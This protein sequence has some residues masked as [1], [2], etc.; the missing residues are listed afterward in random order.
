V[1]ILCLLVVL[2]I[3]AGCSGGGY[4]DEALKKQASRSLQRIS[5]A[6]EQYRLEFK[7]YPGNG[8]DLGEVLA[9]YFVVTDTAGNVL[10]EWSDMV[11]N[12]FWGDV[13]YETPDSMH[14]YFI[15]VRALDTRHTPLT[16][17]SNL[18][19]EEEETKKKKKRR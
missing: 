1:R 14:S 12:S 13:G 5:G 8:A 9:K 3:L 16:A 4:K 10:N 18:K 19:P 6:L 17:R 2:V 7:T 15:V 11:E